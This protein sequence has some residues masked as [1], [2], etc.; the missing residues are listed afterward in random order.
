MITPCVCT[1]EY[2]VQSSALKRVV[3]GWV[4]RNLLGHMTL[5]GNCLLLTRWF[6]ATPLVRHCPQRSGPQSARPLL[7]PHACEQDTTCR[8]IFALQIYCR[9]A[10]APKERTCTFR[11]R[12]QYQPSGSTP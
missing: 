5:A 2:R 8:L 3:V 1:L 7:K 9:P 4:D 6:T 10:H 12:S 11:W